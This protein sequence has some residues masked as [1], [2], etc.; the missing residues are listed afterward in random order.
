[1]ALT[2]DLTAAYWNPAGLTNINEPYQAAAMHAEW[3]AGVGQY[4]YLAF[5]KQRKLEQKD[6]L[7]LSLIRLGIDNIPYTINL[8]EPD[9]TVNYNNISRFSAADYALFGSYARQMKIDGLSLGGSVKIIR[10]VIGKLGGAWGF[11]IDLGA[12]YERGPWK[13]GLVAKDVTTTFNIWSFSLTELERTVFLETGN[14]LP[15]SG[16]ELTLP[17][18]IAGISRQFNISSGYTLTPA[19]DMEWTTDGRRNVLLNGKNLNLDVRLGA[20]LNYLK[21][22]QFRAGVGGFQRLNKAFNP[23]EKYL[24]AQPNIGVGLIMN[25]LQIDYALTNIATT[26]NLQYSHVFSVLYA[27]NQRKKAS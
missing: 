23:A 1:V 3:F 22:F 21:K 6:F 10:R 7:A 27:F 14:E 5:G 16:L 4:D 24:S 2:H 12:Q 18:L 11:G 8:I 26:G 15:E 13:M 19:L 9:G 17:K 25:K 20:E